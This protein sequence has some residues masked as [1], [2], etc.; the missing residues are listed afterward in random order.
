MGTVERIFWFAALQP[1]PVLAVLAVLEAN[2]RPGLP[3]RDGSTWI[4]TDA[5]SPPMLTDCLNVSGRYGVKWFSR[6]NE[7]LQPEDELAG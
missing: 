4:V 7:F 5:A 3:D 1:S 6:R 2:Y